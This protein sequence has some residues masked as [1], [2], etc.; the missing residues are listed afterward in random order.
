[1]KFKK[2]P[3]IVSQTLII[4]TCIIRIIFDF[5]IH[6]YKQTCEIKSLKLLPIILK[7]EYF[8]QSRNSYQPEV[9]YLPFSPGAIHTLK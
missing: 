2:H 6:N 7:I 1:M 8:L 4:F 3:G 5:F 9:H